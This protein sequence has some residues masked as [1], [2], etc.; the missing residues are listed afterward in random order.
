VK[1]RKG[2]GTFFDKRRIK[3][4]RVIKDNRAKGGE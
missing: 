3:V 1:R 2:G 4:A